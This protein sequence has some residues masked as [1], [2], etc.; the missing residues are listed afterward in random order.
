[1]TSPQTFLFSKPMRVEEGATIIRN[2]ALSA[3]AVM[4]AVINH[5]D[6]SGVSW[7]DRLVAKQGS[8]ETREEI[9]TMAVYIE[10]VYSQL[11]AHFDGEFGDLMMDVWGCYD[12]DFIPAMLA[13]MI[14]QNNNDLLAHCIRAVDEYLGSIEKSA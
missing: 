9:L 3:I 2:H 11:Q 13:V 1:M 10:N 6:S 8:M 5:S 12:F 7:H 14:E 4:E